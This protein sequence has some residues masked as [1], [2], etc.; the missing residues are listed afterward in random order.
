[1]N[2]NKVSFIIAVNDEIV[3]KKC[4]SHINNLIVPVD[5]EIEIIPIRDAEFITKAYNS[6]MNRSNAKY[7]VYL[8]QDVFIINK[9]FINDILKVFDLDSIGVIGV[10]GA[11]VIP[12]NGIWWES[13]EL[14]GKVYE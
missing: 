11:K 14:V 9:N 8:H 12:E 1:M 4:E 13:I 2:N 6:C 3:Y 5:F 7:K 10:C